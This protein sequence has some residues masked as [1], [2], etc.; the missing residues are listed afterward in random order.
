MKKIKLST[1][2]TR[3]SFEFDYEFLDGETK[4]FTYSSPIRKHF[5]ELLRID[6]ED[7]K[8]QFSFVSKVLKDCLEGDR[9]DELIKEQEAINIIDFKNMLDYELG[10]HS[11]RK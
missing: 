3:A 6:D 4:T 10:K 2:T 5:D 9:V 7:I 8:K 1:K 11:K